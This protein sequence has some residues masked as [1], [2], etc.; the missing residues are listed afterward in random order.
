MTTR[1]C[2][3]RSGVFCP[4]VCS[5]DSAATHELC[6][7]A[8]ELRQDDERGAGHECGGCSLRGCGQ[9]GRGEED[10]RARREQRLGGSVTAGDR[11]ALGELYQARFEPPEP[12]LQAQGGAVRIHYPHFLFFQKGRG[13]GT[14]ASVRLERA[15]LIGMRSSIHA[16]REAML[17]GKACGCVT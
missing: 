12:Q 16:L 13:T 9:L 17:D 2:D 11:A 1:V 4:V 3:N 8:Q 15:G 10:R 5:H 14:M 7:V 6:D